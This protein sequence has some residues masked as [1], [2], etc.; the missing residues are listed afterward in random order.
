MNAYSVHIL[1]GNER[2]TKRIYYSNVFSLFFWQNKQ[3]Q[4]RTAHKNEL[5]KPFY[6][7]SKFTAHNHPEHGEFSCASKKWA[8]FHRRKESFWRKTK[9]L[10]KINSRSEKGQH[11]DAQREEENCVCWAIGFRSYRT[12]F[13][14]S[15]CPRLHISYKKESVLKRSVFRFHSKRNSGF[16]FIFSYVVL[17]FNTI[18][19]M[20]STQHRVA[21]D[22][23]N[24][25]GT[26]PY[27]H[28]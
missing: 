3:K 24:P 21:V 16:S 8:C 25:S 14:S 28:L 19:K 12:H 15:V 9:T 20:K 4:N 2:Q 6:W 10:M 7:N 11:T 27:T 22:I 17:V 23:R 5:F 1:D 13:K 18:P 26:M